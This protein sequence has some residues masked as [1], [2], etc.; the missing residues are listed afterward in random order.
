M[1]TLFQRQ[2]G[3]GRTFTVL[4][5]VNGNIFGGYTNMG[6]KPN[7]DN[8]YGDGSCFVFE[9]QKHPV[10]SNANENAPLNDSQ[11]SSNK[12]TWSKFREALKKINFEK[13][14]FYKKRKIEVKK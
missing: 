14:K 5:D 10:D 11:S 6:W 12:E 2:K 7:A 8:Y 3:K 9:L 13:N 4:E 1:H